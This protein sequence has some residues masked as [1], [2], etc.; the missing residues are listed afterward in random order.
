VGRYGGEEFLVLLNDCDDS[1]LERR[2]NA[3]RA[4]VSSS[5]I[6]ANGHSLNITLSIGAITCD[7]SEAQFP[8]ERILARADAALYEAKHLGRDRTILARLFAMDGLTALHSDNALR[9]EGNIEG[10]L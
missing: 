10:P 5:P 8:L 7:D 4:K 6:Q 9:H 1:V 3:I 2:A